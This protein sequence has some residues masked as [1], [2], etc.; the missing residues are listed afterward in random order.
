[1]E[2]ITT[3]GVESETERNPGAVPKTAKHHR[4]KVLTFLAL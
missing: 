1:M 2:E 3:V 4:L